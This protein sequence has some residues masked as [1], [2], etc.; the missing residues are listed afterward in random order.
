MYKYC[1][2]NLGAIY[3]KGLYEDDHL[4]KQTSAVEE[5]SVHEVSADDIASCIQQNTSD[6]NVKLVLEN[7]QMP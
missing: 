3:V 2:L 1:Y 5:R 6:S 7:L 4:F